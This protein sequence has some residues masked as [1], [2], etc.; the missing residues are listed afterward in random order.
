MYL[1]HQTSSTYEKPTCKRKGCVIFKLHTFASQKVPCAL[2]FWEDRLP[3]IDTVFLVVK[4]ASIDWDI[5]I[6]DTSIFGS[7]LS[8]KEKWHV[9][10][11][12]QCCY[13]YSILH[14]LKL[15]VIGIENFR[16]IDIYCDVSFWIRSLLQ[17]AL[18]S[19]TSQTLKLF[20]NFCWS[21]CS[22]HNF[23]SLRLQPFNSKWIINGTL[24]WIWKYP[25]SS[26]DSVYFVTAD[27]DFVL[28]LLVS[29]LDAIEK[30][31]GFFLFFR[32]NM[33]IWMIYS[34]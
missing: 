7:D 14:L 5:D 12:G 15:V 10:V 32:F 18:I 2:P 24:V 23:P 29:S 22:M 25:K 20:S 33:F 28:N 21:L 8:L 16:C 1:I 19:F 34:T 31:F 27:K 13:I 4:G 26:R 30:K 11:E 9:I 17:F 3:D 6:P